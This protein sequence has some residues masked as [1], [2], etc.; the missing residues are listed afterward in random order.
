MFMPRCSVI[1]LVE[2]FHVRKGLQWRHSISIWRVPIFLPVRF[3][4][5]MSLGDGLE[6]G[7][8][9]LLFQ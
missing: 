1:Q 9:V 2:Y 4:L 3:K 7:I 6:H 5:G 8:G